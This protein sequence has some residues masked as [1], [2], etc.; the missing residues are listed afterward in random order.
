MA[1][2]LAVAT[3]GVFVATGAD[4][5]PAAS[6]PKQGGEI[7]YG[8]E[9]ETAGGWCPTTAR[10]AISGIMVSTAIY[11]TLMV[12]NTKGEMVPYLAKSVE[13]NADYTEW[14]IT[15]RDGVTFHD[16]TPA[17]AT[18]VKTSL[19]A[20]RSSTLI[21]TAMRPITDVRVDSP[22]QLTLTTNVSWPQLPW[23]LYFDG[24]LGIVAPAQ[25]ADPET[26]PTNL[27]GT[28]P[29]KQVSYTV[30]QEMV[31]ERNPDYWQ[32]DTK[33]TQLPYLDK[34]TFKPVAEAIQRVNS[35]Q[36]GQLDVIHTSDGQQVDALDQ[37][38][39][40]YTLLK[41]KPGRREVRY[42]L[43]NTGKPPLD[44]L[45]A[46]MAVAMA[47][48]RDQINELRNN[49][50]FDVADGPF[51]TKVLGYLKNPGYPKYNP[52]KAEQLVQDY[53]DAHGGEFSVVLEHTNDPANVAEA[54]IIK[55]QLDEVGIDATLKQD[56]QTAFI[57]AAVSG[58]FSI[59]LWRNHP[60]D[61]PDQQYHWWQPDSILNFG[62][63]NDPELQ[64]LLDQ[65]RSSTDRAERKRLY[66]QVNRRFAEQVYNVWAY[67]S[68]W[69]IAGQENVKG[70][71]GPPIPDV[72]GKQ[73]FLYGR[74]PLLGISVSQ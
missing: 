58:D 46:R 40:D 27:I 71:A 15:L 36:G 57:A 11:D 30:N 41:E 50:I 26:C 13:P 42:Y 16:G 34:I 28:G 22:T 64:T 25:L 38:A 1:A 52:E 49:G 51:D 69:T 24:R 8:L 73:M 23:A 3:A 35:L 7:T 45:N 4:P 17:D 48:D 20:Y 53:K 32:D 74:H 66:E 10:L 5:A 54:D 18:A 70:F 62:K 31:V 37:L 44:D 39:S 6:A 43:M 67:N 72:G 47:I 60:G 61:D 12:P 56:D 55:Q 63:I 68:E 9:A 59:M 33:G 2:A 19:D 29:F 21:G 14:T 65:A